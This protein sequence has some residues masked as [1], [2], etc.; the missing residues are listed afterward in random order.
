MKWLNDLEKILQEIG[1]APE[2]R[3]SEEQKRQQ[4]W[5]EMLIKD[6]ERLNEWMEKIGKRFESE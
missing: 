3:F 2:K 6:E 1:K 5:D 4:E